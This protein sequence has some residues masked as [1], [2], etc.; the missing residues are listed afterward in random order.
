MATRL[1]ALKPGNN[2]E[3]VVEGVGQ[4]ASSAAINLTIDLANT[5]VNDGT[6]TR[7]VNKTEVLLAIEVLE[8]YIIRSPWPPA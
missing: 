4:A 7:T 8:Q 2:L 1:Y 3:T 5:V 6:T